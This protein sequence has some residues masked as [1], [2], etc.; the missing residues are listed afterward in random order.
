MSSNLRGT[1]T[2]MLRAIQ[3]SRVVFGLG[4]ALLLT[5]AIV[6]ATTVGRDLAS[7]S[8]ESDYGVVQSVTVSMFVFVFTGEVWGCLLACAAAVAVV[9]AVAGVWGATVCAVCVAVRL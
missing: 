7:D 3:E 5:T 9:V 2:T 4:A 8:G 6:S 1:I